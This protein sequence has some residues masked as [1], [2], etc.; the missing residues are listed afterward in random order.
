MDRVEYFELLQVFELMIVLIQALLITWTN[1]IAN[2]TEQL[3]MFK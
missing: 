1:K 3:Q 2:I